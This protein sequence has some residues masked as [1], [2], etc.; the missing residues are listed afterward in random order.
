MVDEEDASG[1]PPIPPEDTMIWRYLDF[2]Q[3]TSILERESLW[4]SRADMFD[5]PLEGSHSRAT[6][7]TRKQRYHNSKISDEHVDRIAQAMSESVKL[8]RRSTYLN[9]WHLNERESMAMWELYSIEGQGI[10]IQSKVGKLKEA[11]RAEGGHIN[12]GDA[13]VPEEMPGVKSFTL[14][15]VQYIDYDKHIT[16]E[17]NLLAP[18]FHKRRS[19]EH[20]REFR[21][22]TSRFGEVLG[23]DGILDMDRL[24]LPAGEYINI[25]INQLID[26]I[27]VSPSSADWFL[28]LVEVIAGRRGINPDIVTRSSLNEDPV[29]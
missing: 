13:S 25:N 7:D 6:V 26:K 9:C 24:D 11:L 15:A 21:V 10:A 16:P 20:E 12:R 1:L 5:D 2:T 29:F 3:L 19:F 8:F 18:L 28:E 27:Y 23:D 22:A 17:R 4:F 14:G